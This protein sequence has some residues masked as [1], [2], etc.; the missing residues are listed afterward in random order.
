MSRPPKNHTRVSASGEVYECLR[1][2]LPQDLKRQF[3]EASK[4]NGQTMSYVVTKAARD[5][6][7]QNAGAQ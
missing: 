3:A 2:Y 5:Y 6:V 4:G 1:V 7:A